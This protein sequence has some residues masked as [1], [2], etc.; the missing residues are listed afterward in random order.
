M[1]PPRA[2]PT[3]LD[4]LLAY[5]SAILGR[6]CAIVRNLEWL[7]SII[8]ASAVRRGMTEEKKMRRKVLAWWVKE[9]ECDRRE[10]VEKVF[11]SAEAAAEVD[12]HTHGPHPP[13]EP[14][15]AP[16]S[17]SGAKLSQA[18]CQNHPKDYFKESLLYRKQLD[19]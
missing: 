6:E 13:T 4:P 15:A 17:G 5:P 18:S 11:P 3:L 9:N 12:E 1:L 7:G 19:M 2:R 14:D 8:T 16:S 10:R